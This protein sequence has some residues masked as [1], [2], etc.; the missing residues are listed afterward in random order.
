MG[1]K[2]LEQEKVIDNLETFYKSRE[3]ALNFFR[4]YTKLFFDASYKAKQDKTKERDL[5]I[6]T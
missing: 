6:N 5:N 4:D 3:E 2:T 1:R